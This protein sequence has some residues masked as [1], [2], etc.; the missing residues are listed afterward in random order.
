MAYTV[1]V[2]EHDGVVV[3]SSS[4]HEKGVFAAVDYDPGDIILPLDDSRLVTAGDPL[5]EGERVYHC[6]WLPD[7][8]IVYVQEPER[9]INHSCNPA[10]YVKQV[11]G[12]RY[13]VARRRIRAGEEITYDY[14]IDNWGEITWRCDCGSER[15]RETIH[16]DFFHLPLDLQIEYLPYLSEGYRQRFSEQVAALQL[17]V[18]TRE[19]PRSTRAG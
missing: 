18:N 8:R 17:L 3:K 16:N 5:R 19:V 15:C 11:D 13:C 4:I 7:G 14:S 1:A 9:Y 10:A 6:D 12:V 2:M